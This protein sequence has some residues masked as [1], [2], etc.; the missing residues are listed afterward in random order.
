LYVKDRTLLIDV[1]GTTVTLS[2]RLVCGH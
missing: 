1:R 2:G